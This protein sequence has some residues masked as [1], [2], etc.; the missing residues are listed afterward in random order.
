MEI[1]GTDFLSNTA[2]NLIFNAKESTL[3]IFSCRFQDNAAGNSVI[4]SKG[5]SCTIERGILENNLARE[6]AKNIINHGKMTLIN[7]DIREKSKTILKDTWSLIL[8]CKKV[9]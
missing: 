2:K 1:L 4:F 9:G 3:G 6:D 5:E 7:P 8:P